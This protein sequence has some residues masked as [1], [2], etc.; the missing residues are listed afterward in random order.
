MRMSVQRSSDRAA[1]TR[2][3]EV[4]FVFADGSGRKRLIRRMSPIL[5][6]EF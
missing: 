2:R 4:L 5:V 1:R 6:N 3:N